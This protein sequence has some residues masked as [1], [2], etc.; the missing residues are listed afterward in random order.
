MIDFHP[1]EGT[2]RKR[3]REKEEEDEKKGRKEEKEEEHSNEWQAYGASDPIPMLDEVTR[4]QGQR[5]TQ[6]SDPHQRTVPPNMH[7][8]VIF[9]PWPSVNYMHC[10]SVS[11]N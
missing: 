5:G 1:C 3:E 2:I 11:S 4:G 10:H 9:R 6:E 7:P 8:F